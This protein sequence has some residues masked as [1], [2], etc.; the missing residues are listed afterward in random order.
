MRYTSEILMIDEV[1]SWMNLH[2]D[3]TNIMSL[4]LLFQAHTMLGEQIH[5]FHFIFFFCGRNFLIYNRYN[6]NTFRQNMSNTAQSLLFRRKWTKSFFSRNLHKFVFFNLQG[7]SAVNF[8]W[9]SRSRSRWTSWEICYVNQRTHWSQYFRSSMI[10]GTNVY[11][12][13]DE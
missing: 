5:L 1:K 9:R 4:I 8:G 3:W 12:Y 11:S 7:V 10:L 6:F 2:S 13:T